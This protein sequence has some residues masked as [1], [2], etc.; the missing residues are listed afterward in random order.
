MNNYILLL[1][2]I[3]ISNNIY[4]TD[5]ALIQGLIEYKNC[6][7]SNYM[8]TNAYCIGLILTMDDL[9]GIKNNCKE[10]DL[11]LL[12]KNNYEKCKNDKLEEDI[13]LGNLGN[14][15][16][17][18]EINNCYKHFARKITLRNLFGEKCRF[19]LQSYQQCLDYCPEMIK[20]NKFCNELFNTE[21][22]INDIE[23]YEYIV[24][25]KTVFI[26]GD[27]RYPKQYYLYDKCGNAVNITNRNTKG[28]ELFD[29]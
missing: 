9:T 7:V 17:E 16:N 18:Y 1:I 8:E 15:N 13:F 25:R 14:S 4:K 10:Y 12:M 11:N 22:N 27:T 24:I 2:V 6:I 20:N 21:N 29:E 19:C 23:L 26:I 5:T 3:F 28:K